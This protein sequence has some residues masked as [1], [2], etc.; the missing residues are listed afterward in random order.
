MNYYRLEKKEE[1]RKFFYANSGYFN[2]WDE[3]LIL[4]DKNCSSDNN[5]GCVLVNRTNKVFD[6]EYTSNSWN[7]YIDHITNSII[8]HVPKEMFDDFPE[9]NEL[10]NLC[11]KLGG[12][13]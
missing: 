5:V 6:G 7:V 12:K 4:R 3:L 10:T 1:D 11:D 13:V 8:R 9:L 2:F